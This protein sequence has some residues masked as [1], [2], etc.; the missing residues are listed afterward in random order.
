MTPNDR[1]TDDDIARLRNLMVR[2]A[3]R[4]RRQSG[5]KLTPS[6]LSALSTLERHGAMRLGAL[7][8]REQIGKSSGTRLVAK[9]E[10]L[11]HVRLSPDSTDGRISRVELTDHGREFLADSSQ[12]ANAYLARQV[13]GLSPDDQ[14]RLLAALPAL[15][16]LL[17]VKA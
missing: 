16:R 9:L 4:L 3:R 8:D 15:D 5:A 2:L 10:A 11:G 1:P 6:Q 7:T 14:Q 12:Q 17:E 13:A